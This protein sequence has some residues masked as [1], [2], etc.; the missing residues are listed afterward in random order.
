VGFRVTCPDTVQQDLRAGEYVAI[1]NQYT[2]P[3]CTGSPQAINFYAVD[4]CIPNYGGAVSSGLHSV[5][6]LALLSNFK[7]KNF[8]LTVIFLNKKKR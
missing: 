1:V 8:F 7:K 5:V 2:Q 3:E 4:T 6:V